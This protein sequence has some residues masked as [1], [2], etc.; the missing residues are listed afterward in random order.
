MAS[1]SAFRLARA[2]APL[3]SAPRTSAPRAI[4]AAARA[5]T[6][7]AS[8]FDRSDVVQETEIPVTSYGADSKGQ[9]GTTE[10]FSIPV[11]RENAKPTPIDQGH[12]N[13]EV[14]PL[15]KKVYDTMPPTMQ[16]MSIMDKVVIVTG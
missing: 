5:F 7:S 6:K 3:I 1:R 2:A 8:R 15:T 16:K 13:E 9:A 10:H 12:E 4:S 14:Q 11:S